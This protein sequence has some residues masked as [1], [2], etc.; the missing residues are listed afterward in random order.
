MEFTRSTGHIERVTPQ[1]T[2]ARYPYVIHRTYLCGHPDE[3]IEVNEVQGSSP[4]RIQHCLI[5]PIKQPFVGLESAYQQKLKRCS[6]CE[7]NINLP[8]H[9]KRHPH[10]S[11]RSE[12]SDKQQGLANGEGVRDGFLEVLCRFMLEKNKGKT[13]MLK[14]GD[15]ASVLDKRTNG[16]YE[17]I[18]SE[19]EIIP[20]PRAPYTSRICNKVFKLPGDRLYIVEERVAPDL[21]PPLSPTISETSQRTSID[22][23][24]DNSDKHRFVPGISTSSTWPEGKWQGEYGDVDWNRQSDPSRFPSYGYYGSFGHEN[25]VLRREEILRSAPIYPPMRRY[26]RE[27]EVNDYARPDPPEYS[28]GSPHERPKLQRPWGPVRA[29]GGTTVSDPA[30]SLLG[31]NPSLRHVMPQHRVY[32]PPPPLDQREMLNGRLPPSLNP[33]LYSPIES[34]KTTS[35]VKNNGGGS[36]SARWGEESVSPRYGANRGASM[37]SQQNEMR[38][39]GGSMGGS[40]STGGSPGVNEEALRLLEGEPKKRYRY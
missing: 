39:S 16:I 26:M 36:Y 18:L 22:E 12:A 8:K 11:L 19:Q 1:S 34:Q 23:Y 7:K 31:R 35:N 10:T 17:K 33:K 6:T 20:H 9:F 25:Q 3:Y 32:T 40:S 24:F 28:P 29:S 37:D 27:N 38:S 21:M 13:P 4:H 2:G 15:S 30:M 5:P 14:D